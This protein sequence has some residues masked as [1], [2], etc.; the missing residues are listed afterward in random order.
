MKP[1]ELKNGVCQDHKSKPETVEEENYFFKL[2][3]YSKEIV[4]RIE[5]G[6]LKIIPQHRANEILELL[7]DSEDV[8]VSRPRKDL[9]WG[10]PVPN[11][12]EHTMYVWIDALTNYLSG[13]QHRTWNIEHETFQEIFQ[14][15]K[16]LKYW[17]ADIHLIGKDILRFHAI[18]WPAILL[19]AG[20]DLPKQILVHG[21]ITVDGEKMS[22]TLGNVIDPFPLIEKYGVD[23]TRYFLLRE[24]QSYEDG[25]FSYKKFEERYTADLINNLGNLVNRVAVLHQKFL[26]GISFIK[27]G[28]VDSEIDETIKNTWQQYHQEIEKF[29]LHEALSSVFTL[30]SAGNKFIDF[31]KPW[32]V[33]KDRPE[34]FEQII[35]TCLVIIFNLGWL[36]KPFLPDTSEEILKQFGLSKDVSEWD[37][38]KIVTK[39][40]KVLFPKLV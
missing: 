17:P 26:N 33:I 38:Q 9:A 37:G 15:D 4:K 29:R 34:H 27:E 30:A 3:K 32:E 28:L 16:F 31:H 18:I 7:K 36:L 11:D 23:A 8:S 13:I 22:K 20:L 24:I 10:I 5:N 40:Q 25:D 35:N 39:E 14:D 6:E 12:K 2:T 19:S 21:H 1:S